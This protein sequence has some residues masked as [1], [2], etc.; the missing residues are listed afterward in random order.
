MQDYGD[1][2]TEAEEIASKKLF[3]GEKENIVASLFS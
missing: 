1:E 3:P 2:E